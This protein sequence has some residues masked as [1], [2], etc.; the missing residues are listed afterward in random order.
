[1][2]SFTATIETEVEVD[3]EVFCGTCGDGLCG[4]SEGR[5]SR[6]RAYPQV[7]VEVCQKCVES[8]KDELNDQIYELKERLVE[9]EIALGEA[10]EIIESTTKPTT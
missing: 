1:M 6:N 10:Q 8:A 9:L 5:Q 3:F 2:P 4:Q 7:T